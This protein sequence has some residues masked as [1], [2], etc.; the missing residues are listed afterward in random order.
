MA[1]VEI[2]GAGTHYELDELVHVRIDSL[3]VERDELGDVEL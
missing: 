2:S 3:Q 1:E